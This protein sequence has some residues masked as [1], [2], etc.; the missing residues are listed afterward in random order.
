MTD[1]QIS[2]LRWT[3]VF[4]EKAEHDVLFVCRSVDGSFSIYLNPGHK[5]GYQAD[6]QGWLFKDRHG[7]DVRF[8]SKR[9]DAVRQALADVV[10][11]GGDLALLDRVEE[12][13]FN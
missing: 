6:A 3:M 13:N 5:G 7:T 4:H 9:F 10:A 11:Y 12:F 8:S 1:D 2:K